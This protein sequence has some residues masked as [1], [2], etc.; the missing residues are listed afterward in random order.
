MKINQDSSRQLAK[1]CYPGFSST[2]VVDLK[3]QA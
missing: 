3:K 1:D 2:K